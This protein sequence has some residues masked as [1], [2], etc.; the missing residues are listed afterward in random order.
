MLV[1]TSELVSEEEG[2]Q[3]IRATAWLQAVKVLALT[4]TPLAAV[5]NIGWL[6]VSRGEA[7]PSERQESGAEVWR[8]PPREKGVL[9]LRSGSGGSMTMT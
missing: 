9:V 2:A 5:D 4:A 3:I 8:K 6:C 7:A 1:R